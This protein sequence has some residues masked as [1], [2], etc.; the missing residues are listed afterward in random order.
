[1]FPPLLLLS[2]SYFSVISIISGQGVF[3]V[4]PHTKN[5]HLPRFIEMT[6]ILLGNK[7]IWK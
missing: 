1:M 2:V 4:R 6:L 3:G 5:T 7:D